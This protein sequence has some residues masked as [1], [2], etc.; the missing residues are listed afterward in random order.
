MPIL[1]SSIGLEL[2]QSILG[3]PPNTLAETSR[4]RQKIAKKRASAS[5][6]DQLQESISCFKPASN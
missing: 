2:L 6:F 5:H 1:I 3:L 4:A